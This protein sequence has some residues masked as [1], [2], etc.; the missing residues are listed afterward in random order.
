MKSREKTNIK[1][2]KDQ[3]EKPMKKMAKAKKVGVILKKKL[4]R[5]L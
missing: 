4:K 5:N 2:K 1:A 3:N